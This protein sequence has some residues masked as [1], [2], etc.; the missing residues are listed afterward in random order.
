MKIPIYRKVF[1]HK[2]NTIELPIAKTSNLG[3]CPNKI[4]LKWF[5]IKNNK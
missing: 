5:I 4:P 1:S 3:N 2:P